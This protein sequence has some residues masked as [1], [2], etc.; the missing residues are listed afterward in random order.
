MKLIDKIGKR[1]R[2]RGEV[3]LGI[4]TD[5]NKKHLQG[6]R[7]LYNCGKLGYALISWNQEWDVE[8]FEKVHR[9]ST[10]KKGE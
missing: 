9:P 3:Y 7:W 8:W 1:N 4:I 2:D 6:V 10:T 5:L